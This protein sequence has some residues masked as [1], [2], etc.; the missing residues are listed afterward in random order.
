MLV[1]ASYRSR[2]L[3]IFG[4]VPCQNS[5]QREHQ[6]KNMWRRD[7]CKSHSSSG[8]CLSISA[9][10]P[11]R[12]LFSQNANVSKHVSVAA[13]HRQT[14]HCQQDG[15]AKCALQI[16]ALQIHGLASS[17]NQTP[18]LHGN[19]MTTLRLERCYQRS[20]IDMSTFCTYARA[21]LRA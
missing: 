16:D 11:S 2:Q 4:V 5:V 12:E 21:S 17:R 19:V 15:S 7:R 8:N 14:L 20:Q 10:S 13:S 9:V 18:K 1:V 3:H 6:H